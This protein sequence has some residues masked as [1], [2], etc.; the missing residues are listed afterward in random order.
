MK[1]SDGFPARGSSRKYPTLNASLVFSEGTLRG[2]DAQV[3]LFQDLDIFNICDLQDTISRQLSFSELEG[4]GYMVSNEWR[5]SA[6][7]SQQQHLGRDVRWCTSEYVLGRCYSGIFS[8]VYKFSTVHCPCFEWINVV[9]CGSSLWSHI[10]YTGT[11][12]FD[13]LTTFLDLA[14]WPVYFY[15]LWPFNSLTLISWSEKSWGC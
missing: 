14:A 5:I 7:K 1:L 10:N 15:S 12:F 11:L 6:T 13:R 2:E 8:L 9:S 4:C 3:C